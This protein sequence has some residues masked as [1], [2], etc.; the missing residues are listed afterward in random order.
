MYMNAE[1][2][3]IEQQKEPI[4]PAKHILMSSIGDFKVDAAYL[5]DS[6]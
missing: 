1:Q 2:S 4:L 6:A 3:K 5:G